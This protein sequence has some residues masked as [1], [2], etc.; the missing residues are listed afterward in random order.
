MNDRTALLVVDVQRGAFDGELCP[1]IA[2][3]DRL[4]ANVSSLIDT[5][6]ASNVP[7]VF[8]QHSGAVGEVFEEGADRWEIHPR[9]R[10]AE[11]E[12]VVAKRASSAFGN[13]A[14]HDV[15][16]FLGIGTLLVCG[17]QSEHCVSNTARSALDLG[18]DVTIVQ[19]AHSTWPDG[20]WTAKQL[21]DGQNRRLSARGAAIA[22]TR[23]LVR[24]RTAS[25][26]S[27]RAAGRGGWPRS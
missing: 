25:D 21:V 2:G 19:D 12:V 23:E 7:V 4:L 10:P 9:I 14:L 22:S 8:I 13:T 5:A 17:L 20:G 15:L 18:Y 26:E 11:G 6:R 24:A 3:A 27:T 16:R 1:A